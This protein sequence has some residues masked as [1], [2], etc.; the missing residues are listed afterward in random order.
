MG[1]SRPRLV[2]A[3]GDQVRRPDSARTVPLFR[4]QLPAQGPNLL[5]HT[6]SIK[7]AL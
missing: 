4:D 6:D 1:E 3:T 7:K 5:S 2:P